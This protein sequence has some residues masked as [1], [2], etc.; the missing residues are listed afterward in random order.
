M[1]PAQDQPEANSGF[2]AA[3]DARAGGAL[4]RV[5]LQLPCRGAGRVTGLLWKVRSVAC[6][7][8]AGG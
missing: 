3:A 8:M 6:C 2:C 4:M 1:S 7:L 5:E